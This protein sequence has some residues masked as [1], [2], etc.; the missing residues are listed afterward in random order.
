MRR[1]RNDQ[2][3]E[4]IRGDIGVEAL[5]KSDLG[6]CHSVFFPPVLH[7]SPE[8]LGK[9]VRNCPTSQLEP[10]VF[11]WYSFMTGPLCTFEMCINPALSNCDTIH[12]VRNTQL[13]LPP[14]GSR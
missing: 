4:A 1:L 6:E 2:N 14:Q 10:L 13:C 9:S 3:T 8:H 7:I 11:K 12:D 5:Y